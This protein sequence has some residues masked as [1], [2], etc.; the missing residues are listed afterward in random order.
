MVQTD[1][2][3]VLAYS[4]CSQLG[5]MVAAI[6]AGSQ[7]AGF[8]HLFTHAFFKALLFLAAGSIIHAVHSNEM[9]DMGGLAKKMKLTTVLFGIGTLAIAGIPPFAGFFSKDL[10]LEALEH[11]RIAWAVGLLTAGLTAYYMGKS[12][13]LAFMGTARTEGAS[14]AHESGP[15]MTVPMGIL[16]VLAFGAGFFG[17][18]FARTIHVEMEPLHVT[19]TGIAALV[20]AVGGLGMAYALHGTA[21]STVDGPAPV[22][23]LRAF[24]KLR[25]VDRFYESLYRDVMMVLSRAIGWFDRYVIDGLMNVVGYLALEGGQGA[26]VVQTGQPADYVFVVALGMIA[27]MFWGY[28]GG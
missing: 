19:T 15:L 17:P 4:T 14:H 22:S 24:V 10:L 11:H 20:M 9:K 25:L 28:V 26:R 1:I 16:A 8:F 18:T 27:L 23:S 21:S 2:K 5:Y 7:L 6:G 3:K 12:F 13:F